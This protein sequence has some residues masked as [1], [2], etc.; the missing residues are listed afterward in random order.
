MYTQKQ[1]NQIK[2]NAEK[3]NFQY[4]D[5]NY[6]KTEI[7]SFFEDLKLYLKDGKKVYILLD[8]LEK[9]KALKNLLE[10]QEIVCKLEEKLNQT[11]I[12]KAQEAIVTIKWR[13]KKKKSC[14]SKF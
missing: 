1:D 12:V 8:T 14:A 11:I 3:Y 4:R 7:E 5:V 13:E 9:A 2:I 6:Y 10:K